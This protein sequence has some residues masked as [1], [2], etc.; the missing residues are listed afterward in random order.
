MEN[1]QDWSASQPDAI[2]VF[3][4]KKSD[5]E[6]TKKKELL[7]FVPKASYFFMIA[8]PSNAG[9]IILTSSNQMRGYMLHSTPTTKDKD[10]L[11][12]QTM[13]LLAMMRD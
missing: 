9:D 7:C 3:R 2:R 13:S 4:P 5:C 8:P 11:N 1:W 10:L 6:P 12:S